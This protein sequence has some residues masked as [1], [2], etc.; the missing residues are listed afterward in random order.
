MQIHP[1]RRCNLRC[2]HCY[3]SSGPEERGELP[4]ALL[5]DALTAAAAEGYTTASV[6]GGEPLLYRPLR[7]VLEGARAA[8]LATT[9]TSNGMLLDERRLATLEGCVDLLAISLDGVPASHD[10]MRGDPRAFSTMVSRLEGLRRSGIPFGF[11]FTLTLHN[12]HE[13]EWAAAFALDQGASLLQIHPLEEAGRAR[14]KL[15]G[16]RPDDTECSYA[17]LV[18]AQLQ[19]ALGERLHVQLDLI[20]RRYVLASP[21]CFFAEGETT[22]TADQPLSELVSPLVIEA[23]GTVVP[24]EYGLARAYALGNLHRAPLGELAA[25][26]RQTTYPGFRRLC[27]AA[28]EDLEADEG[29]SLANWYER[30]Q[31]AGKASTVEAPLAV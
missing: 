14:Q 30:V 16:K 13:L 11:I 4:A 31:K 15:A 6:S 22:C 3:S 8:G 7:Q 2:L 20:S 1:T 21:A 9:V 25:A 5:I 19:E 27:R 12:L 17:F 18:A 24:L 29:A 26:W 10:R 28:Y 23:D